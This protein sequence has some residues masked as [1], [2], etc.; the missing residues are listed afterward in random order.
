ME[1]GWDDPLDKFKKEFER[2]LRVD[3]LQKAP[4]VMPNNNLMG[5]MPDVPR[6]IIGLPDAM[7]EQ[8][9]E[10][11]K[12]KTIEIIYMFSIDWSKS[13]KELT[14]AGIATLQM[15]A[16]LERLGFRTRITVGQAFKAQAG[17][18][19]EG[20]FGMNVNVKDY[21]HNIDLRKLCFPLANPSIFRR[22]AFRWKETSPDV[23]YTWGYGVSLVHCGNALQEY[24]DM[25]REQRNAYVVDYKM[26]ENCKFDADKL[27]IESGIAKKLNLETEN[28]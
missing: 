15:C 22:F 9:R 4:R 1:N 5:F 7:I 20:Y 28:V 3:T 18:G 10:P 14:K 8:R 17:G 13:A 21:R 24:R 16:N 27:M 25:M 26:L 2:N 11:I 12:A 6:A 19:K 23:Y